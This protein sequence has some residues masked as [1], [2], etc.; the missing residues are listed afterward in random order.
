MKVLLSF[1]LLIFSTALWSQSVTDALLFTQ[2]DL[3]GTA[4]YT[5]MAG[6]FGALGGDL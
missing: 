5:G 1:S 2:E 3:S 4:R 6:S